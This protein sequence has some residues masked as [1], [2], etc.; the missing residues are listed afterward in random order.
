MFEDLQ[1]HALINSWVETAKNVCETLAILVGAAWT[2]LHY[3]R[4]R[5][6]KPRLECSVEA[7]VE[8]NSALSLLYIA[9][10]IKNIGSSRVAI[11]PKGTALL[12]YS[13]TWDG[14]PPSFPSQVRWDQP[15][16]AFGVFTGRKWVESSETMAET[17]MVAL[18]YADAFT[19][20]VTLKIVSG[21]IWWTAETILA[22]T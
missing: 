21:E 12:L 2:Y 1:T 22:H 4:G 11:E 9:V 7:S 13:L 19:H 5:T 18:P 10:R 14:P 16:A 6:Y 20:K 15:V 3:F 8:K 17:L